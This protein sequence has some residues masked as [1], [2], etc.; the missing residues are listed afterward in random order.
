MFYCNLYTF[1]DIE[2]HFNVWKILWVQTPQP[3]FTPYFHEIYES[4][5]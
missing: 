1:L 2:F 4:L 3:K 5:F